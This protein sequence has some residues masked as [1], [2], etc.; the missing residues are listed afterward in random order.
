MIGEGTV[1]LDTD[2]LI[3]R[4]FRADD[5]PLYAALNADPE[6]TRH[7]GGPRPAQYSDEIADW[8]N[9]HYS[10]ARMGLLAVERR[11]DAQFVGMCGV[12]EQDWYP[13]DIEIGWRLARAYWGHGYV[14]EAGTAWLGYAFD[15]LNRS[16]V[17]SITDPENHRS[18]AVMHRLGLVFDHEADLADED[19][20]DQFHSVVHSIDAEQWRTRS[21]R[22]ACA[23]QAVAARPAG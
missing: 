7:L 2:R 23:C 21:Q 20:G 14:S 1:V 9:Q 15:V 13:D 17:L 5:L 18:I 22:P 3:L 4:T 12:H 8:A 19:T 11:A 10:E 16:R 6:V